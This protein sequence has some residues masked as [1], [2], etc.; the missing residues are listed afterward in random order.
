MKR[1]IMI[2][3]VLMSIVVVSSFLIFKSNYSNYG[4]NIDLPSFSIITKDEL[5]NISLINLGDFKS[6]DN[7]KNDYID[8]LLSC[9]DEGYFYDSK[10]DI[11]IL[12]YE[13]V[14]GNLFRTINIE[15]EDGNKCENEFV[16]SNNWE[17][18]LYEKEFTSMNIEVCEDN[19]E[20]YSIDDSYYKY[21]LDY[22]F[23]TPGVRILN[24]ERITKSNDYILNIYYSGTLIE[25]F[26]YD[27]YF[28]AFNL[29]NQ[30]DASFNAIY[31]YEDFRSVQKLFELLDL[32]NI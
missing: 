26:K 6:V 1:L 7:Q 27:D 22:F 13:V 19:C 11:T 5:F 12:K 24:K 21:V 31:Y 28:V 4:I 10:N 9:Y 3:I 17:I 14:N 23:S 15:Y 16:L 29:I 8:K 32:K 2:I 18:E 20:S 30:D 25:V